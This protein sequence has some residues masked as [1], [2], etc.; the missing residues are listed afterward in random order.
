MNKTYIT[1]GTPETG[2]KEIKYQTLEDMIYENADYFVEN[3]YLDDLEHEGN[4]DKIL[5]IIGGN[6]PKE[7]FDIASSFYWSYS[8]PKTSPDVLLI[9]A[10]TY[11][12]YKLICER[13]IMRNKEIAQPFMYSKLAAIEAALTYCD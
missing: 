11:L 2:S 1:F 4:E 12:M 7:M 13:E 9:K 10:R 3:D 6:T 5:A 8:V